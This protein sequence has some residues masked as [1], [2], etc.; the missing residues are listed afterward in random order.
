MQAFADLLDRLVLTPSRN[1]KLRLMA[2]YFAAAP[3]PDRGYALGA[4]TGD[5]D[6]PN[7]KPAMIRGLMDGRMDAELFALSYDYVGD[8]AETVS[9]VWPDTRGANRT[10]PL[11]DIVETLNEATRAETPRLVAGWLDGLDATGRWAFLKLLTGGLRIGVSARLAKLALGEFG[12]KDVTEIEEIWHGLAPPYE[13]LFAW[14]EDRAERPSPD[15]AAP[16][17]PVMLAHPLVPKADRDNPDAVDPALI[18]AEAFAAEW[19]YDG[20]RVQASAEHGTRRIYTRT[21]DDISHAFPDVV[22]AM[23]YEGTLDGELLV[24]N[25]DGTVAPFN[26]LQQRLN[27]KTVSKKQMETHPAFIRAYDLLVDGKRDVRGLTFRERRE[28]LEHF[29]LTVESDRFDL[30]PLVPITTLAKLDDARLDPPAPEIEG[31]MLK[32]WDS[33]YLAGRPKGLWYK[34]KRDPY[35]VDAVLM[36]AQRGHGKRSSF[37]SDFTFGVWRE[38]DGAD[39]LTPVGKAYFGFTDE[40]LKQLDAFVRANT[41]DRF[42]PVRSVTANKETGVVLEVAFEGLQRSPRHK[43]GLAMRFPRINRIRWDKPT[44]EADRIETLE[45]LLAEQGQ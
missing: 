43:S 16:F 38:K 24:R 7:A 18:T 26:A 13:S 1:G 15:I 36:Y 8:L 22:A 19:K 10:P 3:D 21:G 6:I 12:G 31:V 5:L 4:I 27:R 23:D 32:R 37:Y 30:S 2:A 35:L 40:E 45:A 28:R 39:E 17:R 11:S 44:A 14:L 29:I 41:I 33:A 25:P 42:G 34:W 20:I 9:L